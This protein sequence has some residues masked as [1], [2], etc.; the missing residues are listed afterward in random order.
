MQGLRVVKGIPSTLTGEAARVLGEAFPLKM[1]HE[2]RAHTPEH[3]QN[4]R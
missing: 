1:A 4:Q 2:L 3:C